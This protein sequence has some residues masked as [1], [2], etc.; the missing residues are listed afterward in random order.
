MLWIDEQFINRCSVLLDRFKQ[1]KQGLYN[2]RCPICGDSQKNKSKARGYFFQISQVYRFQCHNCGA[3]MSIRAFL[4]TVAPMLLD[5]YELETFKEKNKTKAEVRHLEPKKIS[6]PIESFNLKCI[7]E[8][9]HSHPAKNYVIERMIPED[10]FDLIYYQP[11]FLKW[12]NEVTKEDSLIKKDHPRLVFPYFDEEGNVFRF[13]SRAFGKESPR[14]QQT[15]IDQDKPRLY[16]LERV[17]KYLPV[18][19]IEGQ[20]DSLFLPNCLA[21]GTAN[22]NVSYL[23]RFPNRIYVPDNQPRN[24]EVVRQLEPIV[25]SG[26]SIVLWQE[27]FGGKDINEMIKSGLTIKEILGIIDSCTFNGIEALLKF[28]QWRKS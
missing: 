4:K 11:K 16:G 17:S 22:Y 27:D 2:C 9:P 1:V 21:V 13:N 5:E 12:V 15:I 20:I 23:N 6:Y 10:K 26:Q 25:N 14:Y 19:V 28:K 24:P 18:F 3:S 7:S 8:M